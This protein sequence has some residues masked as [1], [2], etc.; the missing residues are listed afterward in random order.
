MLY[1]VSDIMCRFFFGDYVNFTSFFSLEI[2]HTINVDFLQISMCSFEELLII[3]FWDF[4][5]LINVPSHGEIHIPGAQW[6]NISIASM[7]VDFW[8]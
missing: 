3:F 1:I 4:E 2:L 8:G 5:I 6:K 7:K